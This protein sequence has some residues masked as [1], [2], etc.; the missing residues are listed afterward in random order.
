MGKRLLL[1]AG[2]LTAVQTGFAQDFKEA[3]EELQIG[4][5]EAKHLR[6]KMDIKVFESQDT[7]EVYYQQ[8]TKLCKSADS[9]LYIFGESEILQTNAFLLMIDHEQKEIVMRK[10]EGAKGK[11]PEMFPIG[12][13][14][15][16]AFKAC[17]L[18]NHISFFI[19]Q[20]FLK[21]G[22]FVKMDEMDS[23]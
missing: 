17:P 14:N 3:L 2:L 8:I 18:L 5:R 1:I 10:S 4:I 13:V 22:R 23:G 19:E 7:S 6:L 20:V 15:T 9:Y 16:R 11:T 12:M 21:N